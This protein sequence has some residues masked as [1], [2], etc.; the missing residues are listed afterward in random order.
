MPLRHVW[1][2]GAL[3]I[4]AALPAKRQACAQPLAPGQTIVPYAPQAPQA[5]IGPPLPPQAPFV[6]TP[7]E[8]AN[9]DLLLRAWEHH[10]GLIQ[11]FSCEFTKHEYDAVWVEKPPFR[12]S[13]SEGELKFAKP[14]KGMYRIVAIDGK[15]TDEGDHWVCD[16]KAVYVKDYSTKEVKETRLPPELQGKS[17]ADGPLPFVFGIEAEKLK[18][19]YWMRIITPADVKGQ[20]WLEAYPKYAHDAANF[21]HIEVAL[22]DTDLTPL[23]IQIYQPQDESPKKK[24]TD[25]YSLRKITKNGMVDRFLEFT[26]NFVSPSTPLGWKRVIDD[27]ALT[28]RTAAQAPP[29]VERPGA[30]PPRR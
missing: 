19:R 1:F 24:V 12:K 15:K 27:S 3:V 17:I 18:K 14:D 9:L 8:Q 23:A 11:T 20:V 13:K 10:S 22:S 5:P 26:R 7:Q 2:V 6:L 21:R 25:V 28:Q 16:G 4:A 30:A 29:Q